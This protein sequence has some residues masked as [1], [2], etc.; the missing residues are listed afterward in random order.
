[1]HMF[2][3][4]KKFFGNP[5][6]E[7]DVSAEIIL[8][9]LFVRVAKVDFEYSTAET[10]FIDNLL[11]K[12]FSL[13]KN[14]ATRIRLKAEIIERETTDTVQLTKK[15][16]SEIPYEKRQELAVDLWSLILSDNIRSP[17]ENN[18]MRLCV[19][20]IG[21]NDVQSAQARNEAKNRSNKTNRNLF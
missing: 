7:D 19:K 21:V 12:R 11:M 1:M 5:Q 13:T 8:A 6:K 20:L 4:I 9:S 3:E 17:E 10:E 2:T 18:F 15:I 16:K 14:D